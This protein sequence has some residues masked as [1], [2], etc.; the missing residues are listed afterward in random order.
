MRDG[1][2]ILCRDATVVPLT[3]QY[4]GSKGWTSKAIQRQ[5]LAAAQVLASPEVSSLNAA[6]SAVFPVLLDDIPG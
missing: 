2:R 5:T 3:N 6:S 4:I 1:H